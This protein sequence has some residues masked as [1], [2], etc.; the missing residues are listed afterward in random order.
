MVAWSIGD[1][2]LGTGNLK[3]ASLPDFGSLT[4]IGETCILLIIPQL[5]TLSGFG[6]LTALATRC[7]LLIMI[8]LT[9][10][11]GFGLLET[12]GQEA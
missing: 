7:I 11:S 12:T 10:V 9:S 5:T 1:P 2:E 4:S 6:A 8:R 3:L